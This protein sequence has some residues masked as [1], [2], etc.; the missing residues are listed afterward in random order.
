MQHSG[1]VR[2][3]PN[4]AGAVDPALIV[5]CDVSNPDAV[6]SAFEEISLT[7]GVVELLVNAAGI[8]IWKPFDEVSE[9]EH[10]RT[11]EVN[12]WGSFNWIRRV[13][14]GMIEQ[15]RGRIVNIIGFRKTCSRSNKRL[16]RFKIRHHRIVR[17]TSSPI[18]RYRYWHI[19]H[20]SGIR[21][22][23]LVGRNSHPKRYHSTVGSI[24]TEAVAGHAPRLI[25]PFS[26][27]GAKK[28]DLLCSSS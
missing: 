12:Y 7:L 27:A 21:K 14:P 24:R 2:A 25:N 3:R 13:L 6:Q 10:R 1:G 20:S 16:Q 9:H 22:Y 19:M 8:D 18:P 23:R 15:R 11:M 26:I 28:Y 5:Q 17:V 4:R